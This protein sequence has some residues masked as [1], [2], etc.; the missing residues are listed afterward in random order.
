MMQ[1]R[2][3]TVM[4]YAKQSLVSGHQSSGTTCQ[5]DIEGSMQIN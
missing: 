4:P 5:Q 2:M 1:I 3:A